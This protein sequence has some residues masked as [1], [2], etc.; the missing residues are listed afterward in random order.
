MREDQDI[1]EDMGSYGVYA[2]RGMVVRDMINDRRWPTK[3]YKVSG[4]IEPGFAQNS[5]I[6][7]LHSLEVARALDR[8]ENWV[9]YYGHNAGLMP[10]DAERI[11][12]S[13]RFFIGG[14]STIRG[15]QPHGIGPRDE[16]EHDVHVG[17]VTMLTQ[18]H[19]LRRRFARYLSGRLFL[20][21]GVLE[22]QPLHVDKPRVG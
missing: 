10:N 3:G 1:A 15:F 6:K 2:V 11:G 7:F 19:E 4:G 17:G 8:Q 5:Y 13:E 21:A 12:I 20:D 14:T 16:N 9:Y 18:R 22:D